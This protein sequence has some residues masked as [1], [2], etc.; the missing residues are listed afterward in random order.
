MTARKRAVVT[1]LVALATTY[2]FSGC[3]SSGSGG[4]WERCR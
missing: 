3:G 4:S 2:T 1:F